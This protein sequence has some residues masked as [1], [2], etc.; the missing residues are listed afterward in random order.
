MNST[1]NLSFDLSASGEAMLNE[2]ST[3][4]RAKWLEANFRRGDIFFFQDGAFSKLLFSEIL[5]CFVA[6]RDI[7]T[8]V[9]GFSFIERVIA[10]RLAHNS[11]ARCVFQAIADGVSD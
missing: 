2:T 6:G 1:P 5:E 10:G 7:A 4:A 11:H 3:L 8:I 9:L